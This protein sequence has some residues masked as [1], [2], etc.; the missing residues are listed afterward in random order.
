VGTTKH[1]YLRNTS[2]LNESGR[3]ITEVYHCIVFVAICCLV[4]V[5]FKLYFYHVS[6]CRGPYVCYI[7]LGFMICNVCLCFVVASWQHLVSHVLNM[8]LEIV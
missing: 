5:N 8:F 1:D 6:Y 7:M 3:I 2:F 4:F